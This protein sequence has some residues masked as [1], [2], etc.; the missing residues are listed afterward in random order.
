MIVLIGISPQTSPMEKENHCIFK[1]DLLPLCIIYY[2]PSSLESLAI[3]VGVCML[4]GGS[5][6]PL[7]GKLLSY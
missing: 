6:S 4:S 1:E 5:L 2:V 7:Q 3:R